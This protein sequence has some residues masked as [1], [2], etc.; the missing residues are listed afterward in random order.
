MSD[1]ELLELIRHGVGR[2][3]AHGIDTERGACKLLNLMFVFGRDFD[4]E[5]PWARE[6]LDGARVHRGL[7]TIELLYL[8]GSRREGLGREG[9]RHED[10]SR[11]DS[12]RE[13]SSREDSS[14]E[15]SSREGSTHE[16]LTHEAD[17]GGPQ[18]GTRER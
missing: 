11:E 6:I 9:S 10:S 15:D 13:D 4:R 17:A 5:L 14:R 7:S 12:S 8:E 3:R 1:A 16:A 18:G 2:A